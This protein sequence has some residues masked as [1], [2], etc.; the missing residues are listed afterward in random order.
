[1]FLVGFTL[2]SIELLKVFKYPRGLTIL[3]EVIG[4]AT[5]IVYAL[6]LLSAVFGIT[7]GRLLR[8]RQD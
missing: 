1:L 4:V 3:A 8:N 5:I 6:V 7:S 2:A